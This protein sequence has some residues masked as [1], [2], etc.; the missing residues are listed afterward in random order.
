MEDSM[1]ATNSELLRS[2]LAHLIHPLH[3]RKLHESCGHV[4]VRGEGTILVDA[5]GR[6]FIDGLSGLWN[7]VAGHGRTELAEAAAAQMRTLPS[8]S[9]YAGSS[10]AA[11]IQLA[12]RL[13]ELAGPENQPTLFNSRGCYYSENTTK[14]AHNYQSVE[15]QRVD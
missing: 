2:D 10:N 14:K 11:A 7:V 15:S 8:C 12:E 1:S 5:D 9:N 3:N 13:A 4:W 6:E